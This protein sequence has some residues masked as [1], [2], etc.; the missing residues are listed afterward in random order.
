[1]SVIPREYLIPEQVDAA[2][3]QNTIQLVLTYH[4]T[5]TT[6]Q[7]HHNK[8]LSPSL[9]MSRRLQ[10]FSQLLHVL[11]CISSHCQ[12]ARLS[13]QEVLHDCC[14]RRLGYIPLWP[15]FNVIPVCTP[16]HGPLLTPL[17]VLLLSSFEAKLIFQHHTLHP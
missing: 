7:E 14:Y 9:R 2:A 17:E 13:S 1:M 16:I 3:E 5:N 12:S 4:P 11:Q 6:C 10:Q 8:E 15:G